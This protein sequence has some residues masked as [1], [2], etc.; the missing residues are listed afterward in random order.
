[1]VAL[2]GRPYLVLHWLTKGAYARKD[3]AAF[4]HV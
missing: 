4:R 1:M 2:A 3:A